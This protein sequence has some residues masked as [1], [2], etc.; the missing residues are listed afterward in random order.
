RQTVSCLPNAGLPSVVDGKMHYD[1]TPAQLADHLYTFAPE[2]GV[3]IL[4]GCCGTSPEHLA[5]VVDRCMGLEQK[6]RAPQHVPGA[7]S[8]YSFVPFEQETSFLVVGE[9]ANANGS[10]A[11]REAMLAADWD[12]TIAIARDQVREGAHMIDL[13]VDYTGA[14][15]VADMKAV[16]AQLATQ[17]SI[18][19]MIDSTEPPVVEA[20]LQW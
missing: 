5:A 7:A 16:V 2:L 20:A 6:H 8:L 19:I 4:G 12:T 3:G 15:G 14:D 9:R 11:F 10:K 17:A 1:L 13:C 18:P